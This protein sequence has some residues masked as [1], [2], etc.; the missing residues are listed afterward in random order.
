VSITVREPIIHI[1][2]DSINLDDAAALEP[3]AV[4]VNALTHNSKISVGDSVLI[5]GLGPIGLLVLQV[6]K[7]SGAKSVTVVGTERSKWRLELATKHGADRVLTD[8]P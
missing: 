4:V 7:L 5:I 2:P 3:L 1:L 8:Q 6:S